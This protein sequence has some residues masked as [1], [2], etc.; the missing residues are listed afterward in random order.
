MQIF[1]FSKSEYKEFYPVSQKSLVKN[2]T[3]NGVSYAKPNITKPRFNQIIVLALPERAN[4]VKG[5]LN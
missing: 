3:T 2:K 4:T 1:C 5:M